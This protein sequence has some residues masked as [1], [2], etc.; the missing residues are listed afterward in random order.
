[1]ARPGT[2]L[3]IYP[4]GYMGSPNPDQFMPF[5]AVY[6]L[7][8]QLLDRA[9][10]YAYMSLGLAGTAPCGRATFANMSAR[11]MPFSSPPLVATNSANPAGIPTTAGQLTSDP[12]YGRPNG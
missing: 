8:P 7:A 1:M 6:Q 11:P 4:D 3:G 12:L 9:N 5:R 2:R 10:E